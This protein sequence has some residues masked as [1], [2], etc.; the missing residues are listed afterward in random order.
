MTNHP[1]ESESVMLATVSMPKAAYP[2]PATGRYH[3]V[4]AGIP[5]GKMKNRKTKVEKL[6]CQ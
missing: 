1:L 2:R 3:S 5:I 6:K 4:K